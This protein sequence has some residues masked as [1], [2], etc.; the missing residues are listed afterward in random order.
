MEDETTLNKEKETE[1]LSSNN[2]IVYKNL[3][4]KEMNNSL[5]SLT[6]KSFQDSAIKE[7]E[8]DVNMNITEILNTKE[9]QLSILLDSFETS[10]SQ[11]LYNDLIKDIE[12]KEFL[13][14][15]NSFMSF[16]IK[17]IKIRG[18]LKLLKK[19]YN[20]LLQ[21]KN[22]SFHEI[23][24][25]THKIKNEFKKTS[26]ILDYTDSYVYEIT[27]KIYCKFLYL[28]NKINLKKENYLKSLGYVTL[29]VNMLKIFFIRKKI[30]TDMK[31]YKIYCKLLLE[32]IN[33]L[34]GDKNFKQGL[35]FIRLLFQIIEKS[36]K[37]IYYNNSKENAKLIPIAILKKFL[38]LAAIGYMY[39]GCCLEQLDDPFQ[40]FEAYKQAKIFFKKGARLGLSFQNFNIINISNS[41]NSLVD[42]AFEKLKLKFEKDRIERINRQKIYELQKKKEEMALLQKEKS[43]K[44]KFITNGIGGNPFKFKKLENKFNKKVLPSSIVNNLEDIDNDLTSFVNTYF[45]KN[46][47]NM[48]TSYYN[49]RSLK[50]K[51]IINHF[52]AYNILMSKKFKKFITNSEKLQFYNPKTSRK[53][54]SAI[55]SYLDNKIKLIKNIKHTSFTQRTS[56]QLNNNKKFL[57]S[58][59]TEGIINIDKNILNLSY[60]PK[61]T[62]VEESKI[63]DL[64]KYY[65]NHN[66]NK[67]KTKNN[68]NL[69]YNKNQYKV[70]KI[71]IAKLKKSTSLVSKMI[72][73]T[74]NKKSKYKL[75]RNYDDVLENDFERRNL[76]NMLT[77]NYINKYSY[78]D[79]LADKEL[80]FQKKLLYFKYN[81]DLYNTK[82]KIE[83]KNGVIERDY[84]YNMSLIIK[85][86]AKDRL[87]PDVEEN[88]IDL[89]LL[90]DS[91]GTKQ[92]KISLKMKSAMST[93]INKY[94]N[95]KRARS[96][97]EN[98]VNVGRIQKGNKKKLV[99]LDNSIN[100]IDYSISQIKALLK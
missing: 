78:Y 72:K 41:C 56:T 13:L 11:K 51:K 84:L 89:E 4:I 34:I 95:E 77:K 63:N 54:I 2:K 67:M 76:D 36:I 53:S 65:F 31:T 33:A 80:Q 37:I 86:R 79:K 27:T 40:A 7:E 98:L 24:E 23:D 64:K 48:I 74:T 35:Y 94:I 12:E 88:L 83:E 82:D 90:K 97:K 92:N 69:S 14:Y 44:L 55:Q 30:A 58:N 62:K 9:R 59:K 43:L 71:K 70:N 93:V 6:S 61:S 1:Y 60:I 81:N 85:E 32:L 45:E 28:L 99:Y 26:I 68:S 3:Y 17:T 57:K 20:N 21:I 25:I 10:Y 29:G 16:Q 75:K 42:E 38:I 66:D 100:G 50:T 87:K 15:K 5:D 47:D 22:K 73:S 18:L 49:K 96:K 91:F 52:A 39:T 46:K 8:I 19:E